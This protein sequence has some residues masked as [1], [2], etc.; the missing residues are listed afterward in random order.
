MAKN[1]NWHVLQI[2]LAGDGGSTRGRG[3][4][5]QVDSIPSAIVDLGA[6]VGAYAVSIMGNWSKPA[7][8]AYFDNFRKTTISLIRFSADFLAADSCSAVLGQVAK[9]SDQNGTFLYNPSRTEWALVSCQFPGHYLDG[10]ST[11]IPVYW[12]I[13]DNYDASPDQINVVDNWSVGA[14]TTTLGRV[15]FGPSASIWDGWLGTLSWDAGSWLLP[16]KAYQDPRVLPILNAGAT[17]NMSGWI[18]PTASTGATSR[19]YR[20]WYQLQS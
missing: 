17:V 16:N 9:G 18:P 6:T 10:A 15:F 19:L 14:S 2:Y 13:V 1:N 3:A 12:Q 7:S 8:A 4:W 5:V 11:F 20:V